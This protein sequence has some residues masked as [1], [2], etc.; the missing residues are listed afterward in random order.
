MIPIVRGRGIHKRMASAHTFWTRSRS[1]WTAVSRLT[2]EWLQ[3]AVTNVSARLLELRVISARPSLGL[4]LLQQHQRRCST[5]LLQGHPPPPPPFP[6]HIA[7]SA[8]CTVHMVASCLCQPM[9]RPAAL[10]GSQRAMSWR[11]TPNRM[12]QPCRARYLHNIESK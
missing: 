3:E 9:Q 11:N 5:I 6:S 12:L 1:V 10:P 2:R 8:S 7:S 4:D